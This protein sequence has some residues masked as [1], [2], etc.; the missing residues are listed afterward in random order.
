MDEGL[1]EAA[2]SGSIY[3]LYALIQDNAD[4]LRCIDQMEFVDTPLHIAAVAG[5]TDFAMEM[6]NLKPSFARKL[7]QGG[8]SPIHLALQNEQTEMV[9][10][11][12][13]IDKDLVRVKG[14]EGYTALHYVAREGNVPLLSLF[15]DR[16]PYC[17]LD[18]TIRNETALHIAAK[19]NRLEA[20]KAILQ[21]IQRTPEDIQFQRRRILNLQDKDGN[22]ILHIAASNNQPQMIKLLIKRKEVNRN[23]INQNGLTALDVLQG[24]TLVDNRESQKILNCAPSWLWKVSN[25]ET[26]LTDTIREMT[27]DTINALLVV[28]ALV[29]TMTYQAIL[30]PPGG[31]SQGDAGG[32]DKDNEGKSVVNPRTFFWFY[33]PN[34]VAFFM[35]WIITMALL[36]V[37]AK[38]IM[39]FLSPLYMLVCFC[40]GAAVAIIAPSTTSAFVTLGAGSIIVL[41]MDRSKTL[42]R[43]VV[44]R[45]ESGAVKGP[46]LDH[47]WLVQIWP[48]GYCSDNPY[49]HT[50]LSR[51]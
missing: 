1:R 2:Q 28:F 49:G 34:G 3:A 18:L 26:K 37:V 30:S 48:N 22:T 12:L 42:F 25:F 39:C 23:K 9:V 6:M 47:Q 40:Y 10:D 21:W 16:C 11:L 13:S 38:S 8:F 50:V 41:L 36:R 4:V 5:H 7:N 45:G 31:V 19:N 20:F 35:A 33:I 29:L 14:K 15:L 27:P 17:I 24:Q 43:A 51:L 46:Q 32:S 44:Q